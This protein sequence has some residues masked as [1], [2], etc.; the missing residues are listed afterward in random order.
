MLVH[1]TQFV[2]KNIRPDTIIVLEQKD[3]VS[4]RW[5]FLIGFE[6]FRIAEGKTTRSGDTSWEKNLYRHPARQGLRPEEDYIMQHDIYSLGICLLEIGLWTSFL[7]WSDGHFTPMAELEVDT[8]VEVKERRK[9]AFNSKKNLVQLARQKLPLL[10]G[11][12]YAE[13]VISCLTCLD[14]SDNSFGE[15]KE[16]LDEDGI[17]VGIRYIEKVWTSIQKIN[18]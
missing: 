13:V 18:I 15:E 7:L 1:A 8:R 5:P 10:M 16:F 6:S 14:K 4:M 11:N 12:L 3:N 17:Q 9:R 2:H